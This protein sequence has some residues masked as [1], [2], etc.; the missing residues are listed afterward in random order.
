MNLMQAFSIALSAKLHTMQRENL[1]GPGD[2]HLPCWSSRWERRIEQ[3]ICLMPSGSG[4]DDGTTFDEYRSKPETLLRFDT[5]FHHMNDGGYYTGW[6]YHTVIVTPTFTTPNMKVTGSNR[7]NIRDF[8]MD[9]FHHALN[10][11]APEE[12]WRNSKHGVVWYADFSKDFPDEHRWRPIKTERDWLFPNR[13]DAFR[14]FK[15]VCIRKDGS[16]GP[17]RWIANNGLATEFFDKLDD[18]IKSLSEWM[19]E[20]KANIRQ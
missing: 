10:Q 3:L 4:F 11:E 6:T 19:I 14:P 17:D 7:N 8:I 20:Y 1:Q 2:E 12:P 16:I 18:A 15:D 5:G 13:E 9:T